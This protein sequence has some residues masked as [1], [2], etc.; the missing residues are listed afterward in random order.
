MIQA[1]LSFF[2]PRNYLEYTV[3]P[4]MEPRHVFTVSE[5]NTAARTTLE[6][7]IGAIWVQGEVSGLTRAPSGHLYFTLKDEN[8]ELSA[9]RFKS[10]KSLL[11][12]STIE[13][14]TVVLAQGTLTVYEPRGRYQFVVSI[15]QPLGAGAIQRAFELLKR[16]LQD[17]GLFD[18]AA[19]RELPFIPR[20]VG[21]ITSPQAAALRDIQSVLERRWPSVRVFLFPS[22]VQGEAAPEELR[23][24]LDRALRF[25]QS[26][27]PLD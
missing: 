19:K 14:G 27:Q 6:Q 8:S 20:A 1:L 25:S 9:V 7:E 5:L 4:T 10:R 3:C 18:P 13:S 15:L 21:V 26:T 22:S 11:A 23:L 2:K 16:K 12:P 17:E 24:A